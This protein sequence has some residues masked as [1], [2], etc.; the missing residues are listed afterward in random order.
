MSK[1]YVVSSDFTSKI[2]ISKS[3]LEIIL[4]RKE[5]STITIK[6]IEFLTFLLYLSH[7]GCNRRW[8]I[9]GSGYVVGRTCNQ[10]GLKSSVNA[11]ICS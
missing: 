8:D 4:L 6:K 7:M 5:L 10:R 11:N 9:I 1:L 2:V 3:D